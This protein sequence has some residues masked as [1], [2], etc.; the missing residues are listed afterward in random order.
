MM[1]Q[2]QHI[3]RS[4]VTGAQ[5][6][7][8]GVPG[9]A[10][11]RRRTSGTRASG[12]G[13][14]GLAADELRRHNLSAVLERLHLLGPGS[15]SEL[16]AMTGLNRSTI[17]DL[18]GE[19]V[20]LGLAEEGPAAAASG[21]GRP[22]PVVSIR[23]DGALVLAVEMEVDSIA[24]ATIGLGGHVYSLTR[25][26]RTRG[27]ME[28][29]EV[30]HAVR[31]LADPLL[32][33]L[34]PHGM[35]AGIGVAV[36]GVTRRSDGFV[37]LAPNLGWRDVPLAEI[38]SPVFG[39]CSPV[40]VANE[41]D[42]GALGEHR[43]GVRPG[44]AHLLY[45]SGEAGI[46]AGVIIDGKPLLGSAGYAGE[47]GH[48]TVNPGGHECQCG[49]VG[50]WETE[51][52]EAALLRHAGSA[53]DATGF[54]AVDAVLKRAAAGD[55]A[56]LGGLHEVG[57]WLGLGIGN[58]VNIFNPQLVVL[59]GLYQRLFPFI[60]EVVV[61]AAASKALAAPGHGVT[62][63]ASGLGADAALVGAAELV[64]SPLIADP[65]GFT[66]PRTDAPVAGD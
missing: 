65:A 16:T 52:G 21:P 47:A 6:D 27:V 49:S 4:V 31:A 32:R 14:R 13:A 59:G 38:L 60:E 23:Q 46:G 11:S 61:T 64:L 15:R 35:F 7:I 1:Q 25:R 66:S 29:E 56:A 58:L 54:E 41:A 19:L 10:G 57:R 20:G 40:A 44:V 50:C 48:M 17:A 8:D 45:V 62:I 55:P 12:K 3:A 63:A 24:V 2:I 5:T 30:A 53:G 36:A 28:P 42:L 39:G 33:S 43:R 37:H 22:S 26:T 18:I 34:P 9:T 51:A